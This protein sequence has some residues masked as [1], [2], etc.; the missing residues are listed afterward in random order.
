[1]SHP[2]NLIK[3]ISHK[4]RRTQTHLFCTLKPGLK[5]VKWVLLCPTKNLLKLIK[6]IVVTWAV[7]HAQ[8]S[9]VEKMPVK[10]LAERAM[11]EDVDKKVAQFA[12][13]NAEEEPGKRGTQEGGPMKFPSLLW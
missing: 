12:V 8:R 11:G 4:H 1:M 3:K 6:R 5:S 13:E 10:E 2:L 9:E 7:E